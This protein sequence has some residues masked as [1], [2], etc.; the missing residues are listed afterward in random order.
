LSQ[1]LLLYTELFLLIQGDIVFCLVELL[2]LGLAS[3]VGHFSLR[4]FIY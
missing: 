4:N 2:G 3:A 1:T